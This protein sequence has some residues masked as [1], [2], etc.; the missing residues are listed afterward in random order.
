MGKVKYKKLYLKYI[1]TEKEQGEVAMIMAEK[2]QEL[3]RIDQNAKTAAAQFK[4]EKEGAQGEL[5]GAAR[6]YKDGYEMRDIECEELADFDNGV[7]RY[8]R[9]DNGELAQER[10]MTN[11]ERQMR[12]DEIETDKK[13]AA[14]PY[15]EQAEG[16]E[17]MAR[18]MAMAATQRTMSQE[19]AV[20]M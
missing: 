2:S 1:Y 13:K 14:E 6:R 16:D 9:T 15:P 20:Q 18:E 17:D 3:K 7:I 8:W 12:L 10:K 19:R 4:S 11:E 5:D